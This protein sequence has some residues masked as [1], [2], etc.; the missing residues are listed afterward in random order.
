MP[1]S[2]SVISRHLD[3]LRTSPGSATA[4]ACSG[5]PIAGQLVSLLDAQL[6]EQRRRNADDVAA[7]V[8]LIESGA[9][10]RAVVEQPAREVA[11]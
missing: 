11:L 9:L 6:A 8:R 4:Q 3:N 1:V 2:V 10:T 5:R 7:L